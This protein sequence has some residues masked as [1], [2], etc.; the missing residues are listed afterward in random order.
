MW[1]C[2]GLGCAVMM[3]DEGRCWTVMVDDGSRWAMAYDNA[4]WCSMMMYGY[5]G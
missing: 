5:D 1:Y 3:D 2:D 4:S